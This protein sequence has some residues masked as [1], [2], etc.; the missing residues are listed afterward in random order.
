MC[1]ERMADRGMAA[2]GSGGNGAGGL[3][4]GDK[5]TSSSMSW[6]KLSSPSVKSK[7]GEG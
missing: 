7:I 3:G 4:G 2:R 6:S 5:R 1:V